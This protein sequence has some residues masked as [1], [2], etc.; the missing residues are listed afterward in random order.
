MN[1]KIIFADLGLILLAIIWGAGFV[2]GKIGLESLTP[3]Y[4]NAF[5]YLIASSVLFIFSFSQLKYIN[6]K[7]L[8]YSSLIGLCMFTGNAFQTTGLQYTTPAMQSFIVSSYTVIVPF[9]SWILLKQK[10]SKQIVFAAVIAMF[11]IGILTLNKNLSMGFGDFLTL[12]FA[13]TFSL[14]IVFTGV[15]IKQLNLML[16]T[17]LSLFT[18]GLLSFFCA[19][20]LEEPI[21]FSSI[22]E[23]SIL[24]V[25]YLSILNTT[26]AFLLQ[27]IT[28]RYAPAT[29]AALLMSLETVFGTI[30]SILLAGEVFPIKKIIG[31]IIM[32]IAIIISKIPIGVHTPQSTPNVET[33]D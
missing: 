9:I 4:L 3:F 23:R 2:A 12:I 18:A 17:F 21:L 31:C 7:T 13:F 30:F 1:K 28:Q 32:F 5:R 15:L 24:A 20:V 33:I 6:R 25:L 19:L 14:Q 22:S 8:L 16:Y 29:H 10:P 11:G 27:N 26:V